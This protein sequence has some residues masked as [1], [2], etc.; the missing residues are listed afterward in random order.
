MSARNRKPK[1][2]NAPPPSLN[3]KLFGGIGD[4]VARMRDVG[5]NAPKRFKTGPPPDAPSPR[6]GVPVAEVRRIEALGPYD[7]TPLSGLNPLEASDAD[8]LVIRLSAGAAA[9]RA[10]SSPA[11]TMPGRALNRRSS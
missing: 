2:V 1:S 8:E 10:P 4:L 3:R 7:P 6:W 9:S 5:V 11:A